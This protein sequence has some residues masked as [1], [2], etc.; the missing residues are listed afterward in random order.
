LK[1]Q[2]SRLLDSANVSDIVELLRMKTKRIQ[3]SVSKR[4][5]ESSEISLCTV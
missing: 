1:F 3:L 5:I 4:S 2:V